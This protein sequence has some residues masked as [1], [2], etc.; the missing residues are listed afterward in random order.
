VSMPFS[1]SPS[2]PHHDE[3]MGLR[4]KWWL[5]L[6]FGIIS[7][8]VGIMAIGSSFVATMVSVKVFGILLIIEGVTEVIHALMVRNWKGFG[9][10]LL[11]A[12]LHLF[13]GVFM[14]EDPIRAAVVIT[15]LISAAF[16][17]GGILRIIFAIVERFP[18]WPWV[19]LNG[20]V[21]LILGIMI[22]N[23][24]PISGLWVIGLF[25]GI[26]LLFSGWSNII[27]AMV[28]RR[29]KTAHPA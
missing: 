11:S 17:V 4:H 15:L 25:V 1:V 2:L 13:V 27:L 23:E 18:S 19:A 9:L 14:L 29:F 3:H 21:T 7:V 22:F 10:H 5:F 28:L 26:D 24:W 12:A 6:L 16:I 20:V 8:I